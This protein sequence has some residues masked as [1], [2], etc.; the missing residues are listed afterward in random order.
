MRRL[1]IR[2]AWLAG[3]VGIGVLGIAA[4]SYA[5]GRGWLDFVLEPRYASR[6]RALVVHLELGQDVGQALGSLF[7]MH[8]EEGNVLFGAGF[9]DAMSTYVRS[10][11]R[12]LQVFFKQA[13]DTRFGAVDKPFPDSMSAVLMTF[14]D[15]L[16]V[17]P[18]RAAPQGGEPPV[19]VLREASTPAFDLTSLASDTSLFGI[20]TVDNRAL[21]FYTDRIVFDGEDVV[22]PGTFDGSFEAYYANG[23]LYIFVE[24]DPSHLAICPWTVDDP[25]PLTP[26]ACHT[27]ALDSR[28]SV[29]YAFGT[30][31]DTVVFTLSD[32]IVYAYADEALETLVDVP[33]DVSWQGYSIVNWYGKLLI[34]QY[35]SGSLF[36]YDGAT[37]SE[38]EPPIPA[39]ASVVHEKREAQTLAIYRGEL[40]AGLWPWGEIWR[41]AHP[42]G[43]WEFVERAFSIPPT[44]MEVEEPFAD[45]VKALGV[46]LA[47]N[48]WGQRVVSFAPFENALYLS[49]MNKSGLPYEDAWGF[50]DAAAQAQYGAVYTLQADANV[51]CPFTW[52]PQT[53]LRFVLATDHIRVEQDGRAICD[54]PL[55][56]GQLSRLDRDAYVAGDGPFGAFNGEALR[57]EVD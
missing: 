29:A 28:N 5:Y 30:Y 3:Y 24:G 8:D 48:E 7:T 23:E 1:K 22:A 47:H 20:Q 6:S 11:H 40:Y 50:L 54:L 41:L 17:R 26:D 53:T 2:R 49:T 15:T 13:D 32:G 44:S 18:Y 56:E 31:E 38:I 52:K 12:Q 21:V 57:L 14:R 43:E 16:L 46:G 35:P 37:L 36:V 10:D 55:A 25:V 19:Q 39:L 9:Q 27:F 34:G 4:L 33:A 51:T 42:E 45:V